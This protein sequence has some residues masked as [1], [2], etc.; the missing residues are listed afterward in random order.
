MQLEKG[1]TDYTNKEVKFSCTEKAFVPL[2]II[3]HTA[4]AK[5]PTRFNKAHTDAHGGPQEHIEDIRV[6]V[7]GTTQ[8]ALNTKTYTPHSH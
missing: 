7:E 8:Q 5:H 3:K 2:Y 1:S 6:N 4:Q